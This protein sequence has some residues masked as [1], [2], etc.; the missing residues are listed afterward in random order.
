MEVEGGF[1]FNSLGRTVAAVELVLMMIGRKRP[2][3]I[4][5]IR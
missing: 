3:R 5:Q 2:K 1:F 4:S